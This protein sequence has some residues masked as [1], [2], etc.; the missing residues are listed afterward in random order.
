M[1]VSALAAAGFACYADHDVVVGIG[2]SA[3]LS[4]CHCVPWL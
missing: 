1:V 4:T 2:R 3:P